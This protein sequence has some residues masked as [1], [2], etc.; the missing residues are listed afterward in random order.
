[1]NPSEPRTLKLSI[2]GFGVR[3]LEG[4]QPA[5]DSSHLIAEVLRVLAAYY[6]RRARTRPPGVDKAAHALPDVP[7]R[8][9][10]RVRPPV[11]DIPMRGSPSLSRLLFLHRALPAGLEAFALSIEQSS[12]DQNRDRL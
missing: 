9:L 4:R 10:G 12:A 6:D 2:R 1:M 5:F 8:E 11:R 3:A 7:V